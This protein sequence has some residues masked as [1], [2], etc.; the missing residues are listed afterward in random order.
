[1]GTDIGSYPWAENDVKEL[2]YYVTKAGFTPMDAI[3]TA[4]VNTAELLGRQDRSGQL[5]QGFLADIIAVKGNP[6]DDIKLLQTVA[7][8]MKN[9]KIIKRPGAK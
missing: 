3:K 1:M 7:F 5:S 4:T 8:V 2:E 6:A 9:G